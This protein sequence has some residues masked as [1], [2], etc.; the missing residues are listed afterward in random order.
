MAQG[1]AA[2][3]E[4]MLARVPAGNK[5]ELRLWLRML[6]CVNLVSAEIRRNLRRDFDVT[7][8]Q[9]DVL[10]Q[11]QREPKGLRLGELSRRLMVTKGNLTG[12]I[13]TLADAGYVVREAIP[14]DRRVQMV[15]LTKAGAALFARMAKTHEGWLAELLGDINKPTLGSL[16]GEL[17]QVKNSIH[18]RSAATKKH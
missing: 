1:S 16:I 11:L 15:R 4:T 7:L 10:S 12:L 6:S 2:D 8:P 17:E 18:R 5:L 13:D 14:D 9:F 3:F